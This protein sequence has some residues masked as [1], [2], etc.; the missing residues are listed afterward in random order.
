M[1][2]GERRP[3]G[4]TE[5]DG[6]SREQTGA[7][8]AGTPHGSI[9]S[10][11]FHVE[12]RRSETA[13]D[14]GELLD[15]AA[16]ELHRPA[17]ELLGQSRK[18]RRM[19][20]RSG[21][22]ASVEDAIERLEAQA[23]R[24]LEATRGIRVI[25]RIERAKLRLRVRPIPPARLLQHIVDAW[26]PAFSARGIALNLELPAQQRT[27]SADPARLAELIGHLLETALRSGTNGDIVGV[28]LEQLA[29]TTR[30]EIESAPGGQP[31][32]SVPPARL[33]GL[34]LALCRAL[35]EVHGGTLETHVRQGHTVTALALAS[36]DPT[37]AG[38]PHPTLG[39]ARARVLIADDD[40]DARESLAMVLDDS[41]DVVFASDG[42]EAMDVALSEGLDVILMDLCMPR[43]DGLSVLEA[44]RSDA[45]TESIPVILISAHADDLIRSR[46][47]DLGAV[48]FL[49]KPFSS[50]ELKARIERTL[51]LTRRETELRELARTDALTGLANLRSFRTRLAL[52]VKRALRYHTRLSCVMVDMDHLK[53]INDALGHKA[54]DVALEAIAGVLRQEL[55]ETDFAA[56]YGG[57]EFVMLLPH[58]S[59]NEARVFSERVC[60]RLLRSSV[61][62]GGRA[63][64]LAAS[65]GV[66]ELKESS[67]DD[68]GAAL[69]HAADLALYAAKRAGR[70]R[71]AMEEAHRSGALDHGT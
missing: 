41:Y 40:P 17:S 16:S 39:P 18:L 25:R 11:S 29:E 59:A 68:G 31:L 33:S 62:V 19:L 52:E 32:R 27:I 4:P 55:R 48:D 47:L 63:V 71:V 23:R 20:S 42:Q 8:E 12:H 49:Q 69:V 61:E 57:D 65:F 56:R 43:R 28:R 35:A 24:I 36:P 15:L 21:E 46:S 9:S 37:T 38:A 45:S 53:S 44:I 64:P 7:N 34:D 5:R 10:R 13:R 70:G 67:A 22:S 50:R 30:L 2:V 66:A 26:R 58:T 3:I 54:G 14:H 1:G 6:T 60:S 51:R